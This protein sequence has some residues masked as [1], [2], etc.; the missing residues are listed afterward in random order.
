MPDLGHD[1]QMFAETRDHREG[2]RSARDIRTRVLLLDKIGTVTAARPEGVAVETLAAAPPDELVCCAASLEQ[3]SGH[4]Y[5]SMIP[6]EAQ[7]SL[8]LSCPTRSPSAWA[9][10]SRVPWTADGSRL[11]DRHS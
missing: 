7:S 3:V 8:T 11:D 9:R 5:A 10:A 6:A 1:L 2:R 4:P